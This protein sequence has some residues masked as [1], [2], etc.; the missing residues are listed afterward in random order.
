MEFKDYYKSK[1]VVDSYDSKRIKGLKARITRK[2]E[3]KFVDLLINKKKNQKILEI[4]VGT[5]F[6]SQLLVE[7]GKFFG[8]DISKEMLNKTAERL[9]SKKIK[10]MREDILHIKTKNRF[11]KIVSIRVISHLNQKDA[12]KALNNLRKILN[13]NGEIIFNLENKSFLRRFFRKIINWGSTYTYQYSKNESYEL[14]KKA[15]LKIEEM[16]YLDHL[17]VLPLHVLNKL[18]FNKLDNFLFNIELKLKKIS[19]MPNNF[20]I[21][22]KR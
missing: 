19:F 9:D 14:A 4:G 18:L 21:K 7:K 3:L 12:I 16:L 5:G 6:I 13:E 11:D 20:F 1:D 15:D 2:L 8:M 17:F 10:L 22:C